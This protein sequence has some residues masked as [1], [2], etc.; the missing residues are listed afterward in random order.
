MKIQTKLESMPNTK[1]SNSYSAFL[2]GKM[3]KWFPPEKIRDMESTRQIEI[4]KI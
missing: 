2:Q 4:M 3:G 1:T